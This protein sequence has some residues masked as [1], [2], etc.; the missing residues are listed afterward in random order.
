MV[1]IFKDLSRAN[2][3]KTFNRPDNRRFGQGRQRADQAER[4]PW[5]TTRNFR[6]RSTLSALGPLGRLNHAEIEAVLVPGLAGS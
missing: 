4:C 2:R 1:K 3:L 5:L 6:T